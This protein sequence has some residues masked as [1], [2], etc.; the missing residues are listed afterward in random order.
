MVRML[1]CAA[2]GMSQ[3]QLSAATAATQEAME[4]QEAQ[5]AEEE[6]MSMTEEADHVDPKQPSSAPEKKKSLKN[7]WKEFK[8]TVDKATSTLGNASEAGLRL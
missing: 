8:T 6:M 1:V 7:R 2:L 3:P 4:T 5:E